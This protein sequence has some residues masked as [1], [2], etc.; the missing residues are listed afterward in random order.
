M[1]RCG[2]ESVFCTQ[3]RFGSAALTFA[4]IGGPLTI[5]AKP[6]PSNPPTFTIDQNDTGKP[7]Y[8]QYFDYSHASP[9]TDSKVQQTQDGTAAVSLG[10][11]DGTKYAWSYGGLRCPELIANPSATGLTSITLQAESAS[12][13]PIPITCTYSYSYTD[14][15]THD[16]LSGSATDDTAT[17]PLS[18]DPSKMLPYQ[19][20]V[21]RPNTTAMCSAIPIQPSDVG[22]TLS[23]G[24][25]FSGNEYKIYLYDQKGDLMPG[26]WVQ[27][28][29]T[30]V[31]NGIIAI[32]VNNDSTFWT[33]QMPD[34]NNP[35]DTYPSGVFMYDY[36]WVQFDAASF[37][38]AT[39]VHHY[40]AATKAISTTVPGGIDV[41]TWTISYGT[42]S[43]TQTV[44]P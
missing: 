20:S 39:A 42:T 12:T 23:P 14:P 38:G 44:N 33:T 15:T 27:E 41:G 31:P 16:V 6:N 4:A 7:I 40:W 2:S 19:A 5:A 22:V 25:G 36:L 18:S 35:W 11:L 43:T 37:S 28:R 34:Q 1:G 29:F 9:P 24:Q 13:S 26:V 17:T 32:G 8:L 30:S 3:G 10:Q 21:Y